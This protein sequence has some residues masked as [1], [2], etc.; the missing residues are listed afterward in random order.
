MCF[1]HEP[2]GGLF[3]KVNFCVCVLTLLVV[4]TALCLE[5]RKEK[6]RKEK[7]RKEKKRKEEKKKQE[8]SN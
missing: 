3:E 4:C 8:H 6:K 1:G 5:R 2:L 7:K